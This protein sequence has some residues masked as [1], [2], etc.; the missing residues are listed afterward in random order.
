MEEEDLS[1]Y[2]LT[3][4]DERVLEIERGST[5]LRFVEKV[6]ICVHMLRYICV[7][8]A[9]TRLFLTAVVVFNDAVN[10]QDYAAAFMNEC[11]AALMEGCSR[12]KTGVLAVKPVPVPNPVLCFQKQGTN[13][14]NLGA[15]FNGS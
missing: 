1:R 13:R 12:R 5:K 3:V 7:P 4:R 11:Y 8:R 9:T 15:A 2:W 14:L 10:C 6:C